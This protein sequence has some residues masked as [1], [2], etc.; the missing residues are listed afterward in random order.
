MTDAELVQ[1][2]QRAVTELDS[3]FGALGRTDPGSQVAVDGLALV[4]EVRRLRGWAG[5]D[6]VP[7]KGRR[8]PDCGAWS[9]AED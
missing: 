7:P 3:E 1:I 6:G 8:C 2:E 5:A 4:A 9:S